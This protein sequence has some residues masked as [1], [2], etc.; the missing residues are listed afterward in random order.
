MERVGELRSQDQE[1]ARELLNSDPYLSAD[2][3]SKRVVETGKSDNGTDV[4]L[5]D[6]LVA[7]SAY[8]MGEL[9]REKMS[10]IDPEMVK[11]VESVR[12]DLEK[13]TE[14]GK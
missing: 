7:R 11:V 8:I 3:Y 9:A 6:F 13:Y 12:P 2:A 14:G 4:D 1:A 5:G 10:K